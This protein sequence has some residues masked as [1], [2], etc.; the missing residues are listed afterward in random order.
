MD[1][2]EVLEKFILDHKIDNKTSKIIYSE[3]KNINNDG[4]KY[5]WCNI[6]SKESGNSKNKIY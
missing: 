5:K 1:F 3:F 2:N 6:L 4:D